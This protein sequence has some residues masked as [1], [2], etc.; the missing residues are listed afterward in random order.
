VRK[1]E[2]V[3]YTVYLKIDGLAG[4]C[5]DPG[6]RGWYSL[7]GFG[8]SLS[9]PQQRSAAATA[10][11]FS[12]TKLCDR[13]TPQLARAAADGRYYKE[14]VIELF[15]TDGSK[16]PF[17]GFRLAKVRI[18]NYSISGA[19]QGDVRAPY[20]NFAIGFE[21]IEWVSFPGAAEESRTDWVN[22]AAGAAS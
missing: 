22:E 7:D 3:G 12:V 14:A 8:H 6:H 2:A 10:S 20:E 9:S 13:F 1:E 5:A 19:P 4:D 16:T 18:T 15:Q 17:M 21:K 11:D